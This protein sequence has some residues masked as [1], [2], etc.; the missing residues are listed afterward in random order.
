MSRDAR[1]LWIASWNFADDTGRGNASPRQVRIKVF[2][3]DPDMD[4][5]RVAGLLIELH[6][7][8]LGFE[9]YAVDGKPYYLIPEK[10]W[11]HQKINR[12]QPPK[13]PEFSGTVPGFVSDHSVNDHELTQNRDNGAGRLENTGDYLNSV[14]DH[15]TITDHSLVDRIGK[16]RIGSD[17]RAR[18]RKDETQNTHIQE[19]NNSPGWRNGEFGWI[20]VAGCWAEV[21]ESLDEPHHHREA[22]ESIGRGCLKMN[23]DPRVI[24]ERTI[25]NCAAD[26]WVRKHNPGPGF[27]AKNFTRFAT[28][29]AEAAEAAG[30]TEADDQYVNLTRQRSE[31]AERLEY[32]KRIR[33]PER[34]TKPLQ[35]ALDAIEK[36]RDQYMDG[37]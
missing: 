17:L 29:S 3:G 12:P 20:K 18:A 21:M 14:N 37:K 31:A 28:Y 7:A 8:D 19:N 33:E 26:P 11:K 1:L 24:L 2:P 34:I 6:R 35:T 4:D 23:G 30:R 16:D 36:R 25:R 9:L 5:H 32:A 13:F 10:S 15:G 22:F 27:L